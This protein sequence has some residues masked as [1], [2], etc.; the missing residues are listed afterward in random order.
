MSYRL[1]FL[2]GSLAG[3]VREVDSPRVVLGRDPQQA[4]I[5]F[6]PEERRE[7]GARA[8]AL[9]ARDWTEETRDRYLDEILAILDD[10]A[11]AAVFAPGGRAEV[12]I[13][14]PFGPNGAALVGQ[15]D[16]LAISDHEILI[17]DYKTDRTVP[18]TPGDVP[19]AYRA[20]LAA[21]KAL[22]SR[23]WPGRSVRA[24][25]LWT[26]APRLMELPPDLLQSHGGQP[27]P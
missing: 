6:A 11:F 20:Q 16:R 21:Y 4:E 22:V 9:L 18:E 23:I 1:V 19:E 17:V 8:L 7:A 10:P 13:A 14:G 27:S 25:L 24:A 15:I 5:L 2:S 12:G 3:R 26:A